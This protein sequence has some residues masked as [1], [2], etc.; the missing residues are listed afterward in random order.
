MRTRAKVALTVAVALIVAS[1]PGVAL[2]SWVGGGTGN[3]SSKAASMPA[4]NTPS[5]SVTGRN[6]TVTWTAATLPGPTAVDGY[7][8]N[9]YD[10]ST[11]ASQTVGASCSGT[12]AALTCTEAAVTPGSW[13]YKVRPKK[14]AWLGAQSSA[15][16]NVTVASP[17]LSFSSSTTL[18]TLPTTLNGSI[19]A[20]ITGE[21]IT[22]RLDNPTSGT[23]LTGSAS[24]STI[25]ANGQA[26]ISVT[27]PAGTSNG[28]HTVYAVGSAGSQA[29]GAITVAVDIAPPT[30]SAITVAKTIG[31][32]PGV[33]KQG[34]TYYVYANVTDPPPSSGLASVK[35]NV[36]TVTTGATAVSLVAGSYSV[37]GVSYNYR[38]ASQTANAVLSAGAKAYSVTAMD[39]VS[40]SSTSNGSVTVDNTAPA[41]SD[42]QSTN[43]GG[44][45]GKIQVNDAIVYTFTEPID[46]ESVLTGWTGAAT[47]VTLRFTTN[48]GGDRVVIADATN[49]TVLPINRLNLNGTG[50]ITTSGNGTGTMT[51]SGSTI[52]IAVTGMGAAVSGTAPA[53]TMTWQLVAG[54]YDQAGNACPAATKTQTG[55]PKVNF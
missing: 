12:V 16:A 14:G 46:P 42:V 29:S 38:S 49:T 36:S 22:L 28:S 55:G 54:M 19:A 10:A 40:L 32:S 50:Y 47:T 30:I 43:G 45:A 52:T 15:G 13:Y 35:A 53:S 1:G 3:G 17:S 11:N 4:G 31:Y 6:V 51:M 8:V 48:G 39:N 25:P 33:I 5:A 23:V 9:R 20:F 37:G 7:V 26:T 2:A 24:P 41:G 34:G 44:T 27:I 18:S 21:T